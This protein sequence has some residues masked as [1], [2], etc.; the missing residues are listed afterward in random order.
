MPVK[1]AANAMMLSL[2][3]ALATWN[4]PPA[5]A[6]DITIFLNQATA[7]GVRELAAGFEKATGH[8]VDVSFQAV[9]P[10]LN[11]KIVSGAPGDLVSL[12]LDQFDDYIKQGKVVA[13]SVVEYARV[14][15]G[16]A[17]KA[18]APKPDISTAEA[19]KRAMLEAKSIGHTNAGTGPFNTRLFQK[20][21][22]YD[23]IK[24]KVKIIQG[25][26]L[27]AEAVAAGDVEIGIQQTNVIQPVAGTEYLGPLPA[28]LME[29]GRV[30]VG[31]LAVSQQQEVASAFV[32]FM[33]DPANAAL[34]RKGAMEPPVR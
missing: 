20:L 3:V 32:K 10:A 8:K 23:Q 27:V 13:G 2:V 1:P 28:E 9:G 5:S 4:A 15:N 17:V 33:A 26:R 18:G 12:G 16:V 25:G 29:Y 11:Q 21:G 31:L 30:G 6:A 34:L 7:S 22:I 14:G 19:F 24:D